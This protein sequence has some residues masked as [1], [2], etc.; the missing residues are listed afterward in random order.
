MA[1]LAVGAD[2]V[3]RQHVLASHPHGARVPAETALQQKAAQPDALAMADREE[4][5]LRC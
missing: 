3:D 2:I 1:Q 5:L 4:E